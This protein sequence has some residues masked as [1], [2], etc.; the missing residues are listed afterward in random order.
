MLRPLYPR[1]PLDRRLARLDAVTKRKYGVLIAEKKFDSLS[2]VYVSEIDP[3]L[4][5]YAETAGNLRLL[6]S[7][8]DVIMEISLITEVL[9]TVLFLCEENVMKEK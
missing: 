3:N 5:N 2:A 4:L 6:N 8:T 9:G 1:Y 7:T